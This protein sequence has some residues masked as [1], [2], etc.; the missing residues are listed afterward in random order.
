MQIIKICSLC[1]LCIPLVVVPSV[2]YP[3]VFPKVIFFQILVEIGCIAW[4]PLLFLNKKYHPPLKHPIV[5]SLSVFIMIL[6][7]TAFTGVDPYRSFFSTQERMTGVFALLHF[8]AWFL[9][10]ISVF[11]TY[12]DWKKLILC[13]I[14]VASIVSLYGFVKEDSA[15]RSISTIGNALF[16]GVYMMAH[17][18]LLF[19]FFHKEKCKKRYILFFFPILL[20]TIFSLFF[21]G[22]RMITASF[23]FGLSVFSAF[24][25]YFFSS[26]KRKYITIGLLYSLAISGGCILFINM[27]QVGNAI[28]KKQL[29]YPLQRVLLFEFYK[30]E[31]GAR[32]EAWRIGLEGFKERPLLGWGLENYPIIFQKYYRQP[33]VDEGERY[34]DRSHNQYIDILALTGIVGFFSYSIFFV[35]LFIFLVWTII[36]EKERH[37]KLAGI[38]LAVLFFTYLAQNTTSFDSP[39]SLIVLY[40]SFALAYF[41][42]SEGGIKEQD[43]DKKIVWKYPTAIFLFEIGALAF[44]IYTMGR[45]SINPFIKNTQAHV[46]LKAL[47][48]QGLNEE[49]VSYV[50]RAL[51]S[52]SFTNNEI[53]LVFAEKFSDLYREKRGVSKDFA[54]EM[55]AYAITELDK[56]IKDHPRDVKNYFS[57]LSLYHS[58]A[59][60]KEDISEKIEERMQTAYELAPYRPEIYREFPEIYIAMKDFTKAEEWVRKGV[61]HLVPSQETHWRLALVFLQKGDIENGLTELTNAEQ[62]GYPVFENPTIAIF[63]SKKLPDGKKNPVALQYID[64]MT[65]I[66]PDHKNLVS[67]QEEAHKKAE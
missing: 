4:V 53:R 48:E 20:C 38:S 41:F 15:T 33:I 46:A 21:S 47:K 56:N 57:E 2:L 11:R 59:S 40:F 16:F 58:I 37:N 9:I 27:S 24:C 19:F 60:D 28:A 13:T 35:I 22:S 61:E 32:F 34:A 44:G 3:Y 51:N 64:H 49:T 14:G 55:I 42:I 65:Q 5:I 6:I 29:P 54:K 50:Q 43:I 8:Y 52:D 1:I 66:F 7:V 30:Q 31:T 39:S 25:M 45:W 23:L 10:L 17:V 63:L 26:K 12:K 62:S 36:R 18:F 67:A